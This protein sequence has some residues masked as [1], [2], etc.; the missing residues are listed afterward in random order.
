MSVMIEVSGGSTFVVDLFVK[1]CP[2]TC[3]NFLKLCK[4]KYYNNNL[5][6]TLTRGFML[7]TGDPSG[8]GK[9]G[10][11]IHG[12][13]QSNIQKKHCVVP[14]VDEIRPDVEMNKKGL[15]CMANE[16]GKDS[17]KSQWFV[18]L[19][20]NDLEYLNGNQLHCFMLCFYCT[21][22][23]RHTVFGEVVEGLDA[24]E[25]LADTVFVDEKSR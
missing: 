24:L 2:L 9:G 14:L 5:I 6:H 18:T 12:I 4:I 3:L 13:I 8:S 22:L 16:G 21:I 10:N 23:G 17:N 19:R 7:Q 25:S 20:G 15:L 11:T 1:T